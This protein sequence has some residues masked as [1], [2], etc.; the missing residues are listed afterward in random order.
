[1]KRLL[2]AFAALGLWTS[3]SAEVVVEFDG[4]AWSGTEN[5]DFDKRVAEEGLCMV[6]DGTS[7]VGDLLDG[8]G[9]ERLQPHAVRFAV[10]G[11]EG[12]GA[13]L[14]SGR[15]LDG[16][17]ATMIVMTCDPEGMTVC[18]MSRAVEAPMGFLS[19]DVD[20]GG[21]EG[22]LKTV[23]EGVKASEE[24]NEVPLAVVAIRSKCSYGLM[25]RGLQLLRAAGCRN[26]LI[27][28]DDSFP[29]LDIE[30]KMDPELK[31][32]L[33]DAANQGDTGRI[34]VN[35]SE[36]GSVKGKDGE[37]LETDDEIKKYVEKC[38]DEIVE[39]GKDPR[40]FLRGEQGAVFRMSRRMIR[41][42][43]EAGVDQV[44]FAVY[45]SPEKEGEIVENDRKAEVT[46]QRDSDLFPALPGKQ[47]PGRKVIL[48]VEK[49][50][51]IF[52]E[53]REL[54]PDGNPADRELPL[55]RKALGNLKGEGE[56]IS[57]KILLH[58]N[59]K[60]QKVIDVLNACASAGISS[61]TF[62]TEE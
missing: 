9:L 55:L 36:D 14:D 32:P 25:V 42:G 4:K 46:G 56:R 24:S 39:S 57:L 40:M 16:E 27:K 10:R 11:A 43:A 37:I 21:V 29:G 8:W 23:R 49:D 15:G 26:A 6:A 51:R 38:R 30:V 20:F 28:V 62:A 17:R 54:A 53:N 12:K 41:I 22:F 2:T 3:G 61:V 60:Q 18:H 48:R 44:I 52:L 35:L 58:E 33:V 34:V 45:K 5:A 59:T 50:G 1:M 13:V 7:R 31:P 47:E 19:M